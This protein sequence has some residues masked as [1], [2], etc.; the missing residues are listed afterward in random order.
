MSAYYPNMKT[1]RISYDEIA[2]SNHSY[3]GFHFTD[4]VDVISNYY[5]EYYEGNEFPLLKDIK[6]LN[7][8]AHVKLARNLYKSFGFREVALR[9]FYYGDEDG[10][11]MEKQVM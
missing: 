6:N 1:N 9:K 10:I 8:D 7:V 11:L 5:N 4:T 3:I 2:S